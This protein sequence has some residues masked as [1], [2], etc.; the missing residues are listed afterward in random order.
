MITRLILKS[1]LTRLDQHSE[2][3]ILLGARQVGK[4]TLVRIIRDLLEQKSI[5]SLYLNCDLFEDFTSINTRSLTKLQLLL[6]R[7]DLLIVDEAQRLD[8]AGLT[9]K[10]IYD[11]FPNLKIIFTGS[12]SF[13]LKNKLSDA[14]TGRYTD[15]YL[16]PFSIAEI[17][18]YVIKEKNLVLRQ[19]KA[20]PI[21]D[22]VL[23]YGTYPKVFLQTNQLEKQH[24]LQKIIESYLYKDIFAFASVRN[25]SILKNLTKALAYQIGSLVNENELANRLGVNRGTI[26][27]YLDILEQAF[28][29]TRLYPFSKNPRR[30]IGKSY[31]VYF[32][33]LGIRNALIGDFN[34]LNLRTDAG[35][36]WENF[37]FI[38]RYKYLKYNQINADINFWQ[39]YSGGEVDY[40]EKR[41]NQSLQSYEFKFTKNKLSKAAAS[42]KKMY[43]VEVQIVNKNNF[44]RFVE[45]KV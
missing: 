33:D 24:Q 45:G 5:K 26:V 22:D 25:N 3:I 30:E 43:D 19:Q 35:A 34:Q 41:V 16:Y 18:D 7:V 23:L 8:N 28:V 15:F 14:L 38:E 6:K 11:N 13:E 37:L 1:L 27:S 9:A 31:K 42:F 12:S 32:N 44:L 2:L 4:T 20:V 10:I 40:L 39:L 17:F 36:I 29:I 21:L